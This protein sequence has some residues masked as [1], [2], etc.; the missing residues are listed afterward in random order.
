MTQNILLVWLDN[1]INK[2]AAD[3]H[4]TIDQLRRLVNSVNIFSNNE[5]CVQFLKRLHDDKVCMIISG[6][7]SGHIVPQIHDLIQINTIFI[8]C[9]YQNYHEISSKNY[10]KVKGTFINIW[11]IYE[12]LKKIVDQC[13]QDS[14]SMSFFN[15]SGDISKEALN[16][17][18]PSF[19]YTTIL[20]EVLLTNQIEQ[21]HI[22]EYLNY[23]H[24]VFAGNTAELQNIQRFEQQHDEKSSV[25]WYTSECF[26]YPMLNR[27]LRLMDTDVIIKMDFFIA[28][29]HRQIDKLYKEQY[30]GDQ[31]SNNFIVYRGQAMA[32]TEFV[33]LQKIKGGLLSFNSFLSTTKKLDVSMDFAC[34]GASNPDNVGILFEMN[35]QA[36]QS[37]TPF[38]SIANS[39]FYG[40]RD[41]KI[42]F[43]LCSVFRINNIIPMCYNPDVFIADLTLINNKEKYMQM[44][45]D[46]IREENPMSV[47][48][49][50]R[51][52]L[53]LENMDQVEKAQKVYKIILKDEIVESEKASIYD[54]LGKT[55]YNQGKDKEAIIYYKM[56]LSIQKNTLCS[57]HH[58]MAAS[59]NTIGVVYDKMRE[60]AKAIYYYEKAVQIKQQSLSSE[61]S[62]LI[63][64]YKK[65]GTSYSR[66]REYA[67]AL[68]YFEKAL[69]IQKQ[70]LPSNH[71]SL[72]ETFDSIGALYSKITE[73]D[74]AILY[75][76]KALEIKKQLLA[77]NHPDLAASYN[78]I[79]VLYEVTK[80]HLKAYSLYEEA[81]HNGQQT[82]PGNHP[83]LKVFRNNLDRVK[84]KL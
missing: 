18:G 84:N 56:A 23:C 72:I 82:L 55:K 7:L 4:N 20:K 64:S 80:N 61:H 39:S 42:L 6:S 27:A 78:N 54:R 12:V 16:Q 74:N 52:G 37:I 22:K 63:L 70:S 58:D 21:G 75:H 31:L 49:W 32:R 46:R 24:K 65:I 41:D 53:M 36:E 30:G 11:S 45:S 38:A 2:A 34:Q 62:D 81:I 69:E 83:H 79:G 60:Y 33:K 59:Y 26:L 35:I 50:Y 68:S 13:E 51:F 66:M 10:P 67:K 44:L 15:T 29:L 77:S 9:D 5:E 40:E 8:L 43:G 3:C 57:N 17:M 14:I 73:Y 19:I 25:W 28:D 71:R 47:K 48:G 1:N 76:K